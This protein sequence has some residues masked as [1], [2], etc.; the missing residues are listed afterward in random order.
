LLLLSIFANEKNRSS[1]NRMAGKKE[2]AKISF[3]FFHVTCTRFD[4][5]PKNYASSKTP[6]LPSL[7]IS[8]K[9]FTSPL[10]PSFHIRLVTFF[11][12]RNQVG[13]F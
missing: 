2:K 6:L 10:F 1:S 3:H 13:R 4:G 5:E 11:N 12:P 8:D 7:K 9:N